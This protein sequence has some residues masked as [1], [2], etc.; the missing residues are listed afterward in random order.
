MGVQDSLLPGLRHFMKQSAR[1][2]LLV[3]LLWMLLLFV[4]FTYFTDPQVNQP[5][6]AIFP[7][8]SES[9]HVTYV[10]R[11]TRV[12]MAS[13]NSRWGLYAERR[14]PFHRRQVLL[15]LRDRK[16]FNFR[17]S[18]F[19]DWS[20]VRGLWKGQVSSK[21]LSNRLQRVMKNYVHSNKHN[22]LY[23]GQQEASKSGQE[24][25]CQMKQQAKL[26][27]LDGSEQPFAHLGFQQ[28]APP[29]LQQMYTTCAVVTSAGAIL[30]SSL[31]PEIGELGRD[32]MRIYTL[33][34]KSLE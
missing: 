12:I 25:L 10:Q 9:S 26:R 21:L 8:N 14:G 20:V 7:F 24:I 29:K 23:Q 11:S 32:N 30:N 17:N 6:R 1:L 3:L 22:V 13:Q 18:F 4:V 2:L 34:V 16:G 19:S 5:H 27:T 15:P 28:L 31:G 33:V